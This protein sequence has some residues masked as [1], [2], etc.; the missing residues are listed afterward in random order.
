MERGS[1]GSP[2][3]GG[4]SFL[5]SHCVGGYWHGNLVV[6]RV[7]PGRINVVLLINLNK[8]CCSLST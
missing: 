8:A 6:R 5:L 4:Q 3:C 2:P 1:V 7:S